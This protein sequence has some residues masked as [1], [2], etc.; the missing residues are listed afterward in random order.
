MVEPTEPGS[1]W[2][3]FYLH[4]TSWPL[5]ITCCRVSPWNYYI[6]FNILFI[7][8]CSLDALKKASK[9][10]ET[11]IKMEIVKVLQQSSYCRKRSGWWNWALTS[12]LL[13][14]TTLTLMSSL[15]VTSCFQRVNFQEC[16]LVI[17]NFELPSAFLY[18]LCELLEK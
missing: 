6:N 7:V 16:N 3:N 12:Y 15:A 8:F 11:R 18:V 17:L 5:R 14:R 2:E 4:L 9:K 10:K 1:V 13:A